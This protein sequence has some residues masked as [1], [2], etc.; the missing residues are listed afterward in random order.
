VSDPTDKAQSRPP[1]V[2]YA[3]WAVILGSIALVVSAYHQISTLHTLDTR[4]SVTRLLQDE[5]NGLGITVDGWLAALRVLSMICGACAAAAAILG[6]QT[7]QR[8]RSA[9]VVLLVLAVPLVISGLATGSFFAAIILAAVVMLWLPAANA[10][11]G[12]SGDGKMGTMS[13]APSPPGPAAGQPGPYG[14]QSG[15]PGPYGPSYGQPSYGQA[16]QYGAPQ[17]PQQPAMPYAPYSG[18]P[19]D[20]D[21]RPGGVTAAAVITFIL[22]GLT[23]AF[24][25][26]LMV[27]SAA[28]DDLYRRL[29]DQG[30]DMHGVTRS[31]L[32]A[33]LLAGGAV[34]AILGVAAIIAAIFVMRRSRGARVTLT[35]LSGLTIALSLAG[36][37]GV[38][39]IVTLGGAVATIVLLFQ[40]RSN[41]WFARRS[42]L[43][44]PYPGAPGGPWQQG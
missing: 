42:G 35:V 21:V 25:L 12:A 13:E 40:R 11:F 36:I 27:G 2:T 31:E 9:R 39:P 34:L 6:W 14:Q 41:D 32:R 20:P 15:Q 33:G 17:A 44:S 10:W 23:T 19:P 3:G 26:L 5:P 22:A 16:P 37:T 38:L 29:A 4:A 8:S 30:Y 24:G 18:M 1:Q 7:M 43:R 28:V